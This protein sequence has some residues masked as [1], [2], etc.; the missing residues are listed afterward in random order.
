MSQDTLHFPYLGNRSILEHVLHD[1]HWIG[2]S[3]LRNSAYKF[4]NLM[5]VKIDQKEQN[6]ELLIEF[7]PTALY[8]TTWS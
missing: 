5:L 6:T 3:Y 4:L 2:R 8:L 1:H 7:Y